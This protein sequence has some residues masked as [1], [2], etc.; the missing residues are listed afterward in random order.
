MDE[1]NAFAFCADSWFLVDEPD[2]MCPASLER[3]VEIGHRETNV[4]KTGSA[5]VD[6]FSDGCVRTRRLE[7]LDQRVAHCQSDNVGAVGVVERHEG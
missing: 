5:S 3:A 7:Q 2:A 6:E 4:V 1:R